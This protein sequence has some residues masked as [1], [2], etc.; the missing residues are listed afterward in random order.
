MKTVREK[1]EGKL[2]KDTWVTWRQSFKSHLS[3]QRYNA[4]L[5]FRLFQWWK[6]KLVEFDGMEAVGDHFLNGKDY[7][8]AER[9]WNSWRRASELRNAEKSVVDS[10]NLRIMVDAMKVWKKHA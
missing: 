1:R 10:V 7:A 3:G 9:F 5:V 2:R 6:T 4:R 8:T